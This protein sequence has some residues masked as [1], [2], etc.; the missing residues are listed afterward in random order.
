M[1]ATM[2]SPVVYNPYNPTCSFSPC[3]QQVVGQ[4]DGLPAVQYAAC[5]SLFGS[6]T[7][8]TVTPAIDIVF[9]TSTATSS[10]TDIIISL[11]TT[12]STASETLTS[13]VTDIE[14]S[15][16]YTTT[17]ASTLT[18]G[19]AAPTYILVKKDG[20]LK[21]KK[22][23]KK[24]R[25]ACKASSVSSSAPSSSVSSSA[26]SSS[27]ITEASSSSSSAWSSTAESSTAPFPEAT[28]C[29]SL[30]AYSSAC[31]CID[32]VSSASAVT[33]SASASTSVVY[34][35]VSTTIPSVSIS[36]V[37]VAETTVIVEHVTTTTTTVLQTAAATVVTV[38]TTTT[39]VGPTQTAYVVL[40]DG[41]RAGKPLNVVS[42]YVQ[43]ASTGA[44]SKITVTVAEGSPW[45]PGQT[46]V[47]MWLHSANSQVGVM[48]FE[49]A[50][51]GAANGDIAVKCT[52][53]PGTGLLSCTTA[54]GHS[55]FLVCGAYMYLANPT[56]GQSSCTET[57]LK[58]SPWYT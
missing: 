32:A 22:K 34:D 15:T 3:L 54:Q 50:G 5:T 51:Q 49:T 55:K 12:T 52:V 19:T 13:Y 30:E 42:S 39:P 37:T 11:T 33:E 10:Y 2:T 58:L 29:P 45:I 41:S 8:S 18:V 27:A 7:V 40:L 38:T 43:V 56:F 36:I 25:G 26:P 44:G 48:F 20:G 46:S 53:N 35:T 31:A 17:I 14:S 9:S 24:K 28:H 23:K 47:T 57:R 4:V 6:P 16:A 1:P 21:R